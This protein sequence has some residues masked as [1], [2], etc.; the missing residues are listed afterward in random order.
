ME[1][2][3]SEQAKNGMLFTMAIEIL[4]KQMGTMEMALRERVG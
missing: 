2:L 3:V 4:K 1:R